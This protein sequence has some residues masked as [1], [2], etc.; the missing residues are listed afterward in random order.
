[1]AINHDR[2]IEEIVLHLN[3]E[4][5]DVYTNQGHEHNAGIDG[6]YPDVIL[7]EKGSTTVK[8]IMEIETIDSVNEE[9][10]NQWKKYY[11]EIKATFYLVVPASTLNRAKELCQRFGINARYTTYIENEGKLIFDFQ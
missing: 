10:K 1:M 11:D 2:I 7:T 5:Y 6:N 4:K 9:S 8:F 3:Q